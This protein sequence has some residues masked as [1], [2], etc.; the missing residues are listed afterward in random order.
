MQ[1][2]AG[3]E[4][5]RRR[6]RE[7]RRERRS[8]RQNEGAACLHLMFELRNPKPQE[9][10]ER[11]SFLPQEMD[12]ESVGKLNNNHCNHMNTSG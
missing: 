12:Q 9:S 10:G 5:V 2:R 1:G 6:G 3:E 8:H 11:V 7:R 4:D